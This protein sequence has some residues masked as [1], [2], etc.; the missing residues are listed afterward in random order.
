MSISFPVSLKEFIKDPI[1]SLLFLCLVAIMYL[2]IDNKMIYKEQI[3]KQ[4][5]RIEVL[6]SKVDI[7]ENKL[8]EINKIKL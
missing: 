6:E 2:Y 5:K 4:E 3:T 8:L 1:K 7:L